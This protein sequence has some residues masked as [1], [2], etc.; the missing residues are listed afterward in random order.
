MIENCSGVI[1]AG[2]KNSRLPGKK[3]TFRQVGNQIILERICHVFKTL[4]TDVILVVKEPADFAMQDMMVVT[5]IFNEGGAL[6]GL[7]SGLFYAVNPNAY[8]TACDT[9]FLNPEMIRYLVSRV[10]PGIDVVVPRT[11]NGLE[12]LNAVYTKQFLSKVEANLEQG[13]FKINACYSKRKTMELPETLLRKLDPALTF[14]F[15]INTR[16]DLARARKMAA[17][18]DGKEA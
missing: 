1:L 3:K 16:E 17:V 10:R 2:G 14:L 11:A 9:P 12:P 6:A 18:P 5:D 7:H 13:Q 4:F 8:V 15:N